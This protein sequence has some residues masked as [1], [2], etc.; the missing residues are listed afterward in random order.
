MASRSRSAPWCSPPVSARACGRSPTRCRSRW[1]RS[2]GRPLLD[3]V[4]DRLAEA[5]VET[6]VVNVHYLADQIERH[7][8]GPHAAADRDLRRARRT[9]RHRRRR[10]QGAAAARNR[11]VLPR[12]FRQLWIDGVHANLPRLAAAFDP[13]RMDALLLLAPTTASIGYAGRGDFAMAPDGRLRAA[14]SARWRRSSMR[15]PRSSRPRCSPMRR[16][17]QFSLTTHV[18]PRDRGRAAATACGSTASGCMSARP[19]RDRGGGSARFPRVPL[20][21]QSA[22]TLPR[23]DGAM[24]PPAS[25]PFPPRRRSCRR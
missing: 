10:R 7:L 11:A 22:V 25:S 8:A 20:A 15:A 9:A 12:Q 6:A 17:A 18:R 14:P 5:G 16:R 4:L 1:S 2:P 24:A 13:A 3:H 23:Y 21:F 19:T